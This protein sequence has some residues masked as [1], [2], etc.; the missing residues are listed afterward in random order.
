VIDKLRLPLEYFFR[1]DQIRSAADRLDARETDSPAVP[2][3]IPDT[4][5][6][7]DET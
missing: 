1:H 7:G 5:S 4:E 6:R 2:S 3:P